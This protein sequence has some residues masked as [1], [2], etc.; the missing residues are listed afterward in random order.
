MYENFYSFVLS[1]SMGQYFTPKHVSKLMVKLT[2]IIRG[3][4]IDENDVVYDPTCGVGG[5]LLCAL[6]NKPMLIGVEYAYDVATI[7]RINMIL[8]SSKFII[9]EGDSLST[10]IKTQLLKNN[11]IPNVCLLNPPFPSSINDPKVYKFI[12]H[13]VD[14]AMDN[15][16]ITALV[17]TSCILKHGKLDDNEDNEKLFRK[18][19]LEKCQLKAVITLPADIFYPKANVNTSIVVL[20]KTNIPHDIKQTV[21]FSRCDDDGHTLKKSIN[22]RV[23]TN[24]NNDFH[25]LINKWT[26]EHDDVPSKYIESYLSQEEVLM[27]YEWTPESKL[28]S[29]LLNTNIIN[30]YKEIYHQLLSS[31]IRFNILTDNFS[32]FNETYKMVNS[33][34]IENFKKA[35]IKKYKNNITIKDL[36]EHTNGNFKVNENEIYNDINTAV[37]SASEFNNG[38]VKFI[39]SVGYNNGITVSKNGKPCVCRVHTRIPCVITSEV[40]WLKPKYNFNKYHLMILAALIEQNRWKFNYGR[41][42][43]WNRIKD[44]SII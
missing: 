6:K 38:V 22:S 35:I 4:N 11:I 43:T 31:Y 28:K 2:E 20:Q 40:L 44:I 18:K 32:N 34:T 10:N 9:Y 37:V 17:P 7:A 8:Q 21:I 16:Y 41:K 5:L 27:G 13:S 23:L 26:Q 1:N 24:E 39:N 42:L 25:M 30:T 19:I 36:F 29:E 12:E 33:K 3:N 15:A 14:V